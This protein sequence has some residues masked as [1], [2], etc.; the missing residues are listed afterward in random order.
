MR[1]WEKKYLIGARIKIL[2]F[3]TIKKK[4]ILPL[5]VTVYREDIVD[6]GQGS[7][8]SILGRRHVHKVSLAVDTKDKDT[9]YTEDHLVSAVELGGYSSW[10]HIAT[11]L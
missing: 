7:V 8:P 1:T 6:C 9:G 3:N 2:F 5:L 11:I 4:K 10:H